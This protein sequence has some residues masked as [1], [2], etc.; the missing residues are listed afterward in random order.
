VSTIPYRADI[1]GLRAVSILAVVAYHADFP[2]A[3]G[4]FVGV[5]VFFVISGYLITSLLAKELIESGRIDLIRF[6]ARRIRRLL[7]SAL[8]VIVISSV[9]ATQILPPYDLRTAG[10]DLIAASAYSVNWRLAMRAVDYLA[11]GERHSP[12]LHASL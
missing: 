1:D 12:Y 6:W 2:F 8:A 7:P 4:G 5:D 11:E 10:G 3:T 9:L